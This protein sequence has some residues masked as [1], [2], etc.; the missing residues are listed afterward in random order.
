VSKK[1]ANSGSYPYLFILNDLKT[2]LVFNLFLGAKK[3]IETSGDYALPWS[4]S[5]ESATS[6]TDQI[7]ECGCG[8]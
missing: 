3:Y 6:P 5:S 4:L 8:L 2:F 7:K 1:I